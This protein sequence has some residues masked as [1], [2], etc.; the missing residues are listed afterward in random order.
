MMHSKGYA[1]LTRKL[2]ATADKLC[3]GRLVMAHEGGYSPSYVP[4]CGLAVL[5]AL[6]G[7][8]SGVEDPFWHS[9]KVWRGKICNRIR[10]NL[11]QPSKTN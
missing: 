7:K 1:S 5:E 8:T 11:L 10:K 6:A 2:M 3:G 9:L 4:F